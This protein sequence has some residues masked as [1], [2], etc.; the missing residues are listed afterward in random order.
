MVE[1]DSNAAYVPNVVKKKE[2]R[3]TQ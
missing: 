2:K 1:I 3:E